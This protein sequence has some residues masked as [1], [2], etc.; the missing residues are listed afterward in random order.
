MAGVAMPKQTKELKDL[1]VRRLKEPGMHAVGGVTGLYLQVLP[2][3]ARTWI[4][5]AMVA[6]KRREA[7][8]GGYPTVTLEQARED[9]RAARKKIKDGID[10]IEASRAARSAL[11]AARAAALTFEQCV[12][13]YI[14]SNK[15]GWKNQKHAAQWESTLKAYAGPVMGKLLVRDVD[16][17]HVLAVLEPIWETKT[18]TASR[19]RGR[20]EAVLD[21]ATPRR[22]RSG[23][24]PARWRG[25]L[26]KLLPQPKKVARG[27]HH[28]ALPVDDLGRFMPKLRERTGMG[29]RALEFAILTATRSGEVREATWSEFNLDAKVWIIPKGRMKAEK[30]QR[31]P[32]SDAAL[33]LLKALP[34]MAGTDVVFPG[35][36]GQPLSDMTLTSVIRRMHEDEVSAGRPGFVDPLQTDADGAPRVATPHGFRSTFRDW[37]GERTAH[38]REVI[39]HALAHQLKDKAEA[40]YQRGTLF[41]KRRRLMGD[42]AAFLDRPA[43]P[44]EVIELRRTEK[45]P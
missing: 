12:A 23:E 21:W 43:L 36:K 41:D 28:P 45:A 37:A 1:E 35:T 33:A 7:G 30:E 11:A 24:N 40:A 10:P 16:L 8:L 20:I 14:E 31:V 18:E 9:A 34:K 27:D 15:A 13:K 25:H 4:L 32:L 17:H 38:P 39:E 26:D 2:T 19:V 29:P 44:A 5:R 22:Y 3:G 42:W 6:G